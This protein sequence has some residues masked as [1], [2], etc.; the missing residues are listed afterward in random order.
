MA[1]A[2]HELWAFQVL[3]GFHISI[4]QTASAAL[5][6]CADDTE[7]NGGGD[8]DGGGKS[9]RLQFNFVFFLL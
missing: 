8:D 1:F 2:F 3:M 9:K 6:V 4:C 5:C 7:H